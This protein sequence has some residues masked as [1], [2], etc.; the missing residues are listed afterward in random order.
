VD[1]T[2]TEER[3][4]IG[5]LLD[6]IWFEMKH[7]PVRSKEQ[8]LKLL[9]DL[10]AAEGI[11]YAIIG[12]MALQVHVADPRT[13]VDVD[14]ALL[15]RE[16]VPRTAL[17]ALGFKHTGSFEHSENFRS[18]DGIMVQF[19]GEPEWQGVVR[20]AEIHDAFDRRIPFI[21]PIDLV[22]AKLRA[23]ADPGR[24][25]SKR[26]ID[27]ADITTLLEEHADLASLLTED[28]MARIARL[29]AEIGSPL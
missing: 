10:L 3:L 15:A 2:V 14:V 9:V 20:R 1:R 8:T 27:V 11:P 23:A 18:P 24:R 6:T 21:S 19:S 26:L 28:E 13:T 17:E 12:G 4:R 22:R 7:Q 5:F 25:R 16:D 29:P